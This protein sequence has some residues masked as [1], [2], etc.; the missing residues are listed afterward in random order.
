M[1]VKKTTM[2]RASKITIKD[3]IVELVHAIIRSSSQ[4]LQEEVLSEL[5]GIWKNLTQK[6][7]HDIIIDMR[8]WIAIARYT[9]TE[10]TKEFLNWVSEE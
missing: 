10:D 9:P 6:Q 3:N 1:S 8:W 4:S 7:Q 2:T 5:R